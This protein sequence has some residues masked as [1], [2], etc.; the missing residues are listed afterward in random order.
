MTHPAALTTCSLPPSLPCAQV[1]FIGW[2]GVVPPL[3]WLLNQVSEPIAGLV[4]RRTGK[5]FFLADGPAD[6]AG[7]PALP[8]ARTASGTSAGA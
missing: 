8:L 7:A 3:N 5:Q 2:I 4:F 1:P 6:H